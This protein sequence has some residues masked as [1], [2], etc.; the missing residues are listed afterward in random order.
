MDRQNTITVTTDTII[1]KVDQV[2]SISSVSLV[3]S[4]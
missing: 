4:T 3:T 2:P 1:R